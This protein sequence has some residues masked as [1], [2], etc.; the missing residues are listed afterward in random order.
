VFGSSAPAGCCCARSA[1]TALY[2]LQVYNLT[3]YPHLV[4]LLE[5]LGVDTEPSD[6][7]FALS[8]DG[9]AFEWGSRGL[10]ALFCQR[11]NLVSPTFW[12]MVVDVVRFGRGAREVGWATCMVLLYARSAALA[13]HTF[14]TS[15][16]PTAQVLDPAESGRFS[17]MST[18]DYLRLRRYSQAFVRHYFLPMCAAV[19]SVPESQASTWS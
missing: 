5:T 15:P 1:L 18:G 9:G 4:G 12:R 19:W 6:M 16:S 10:A 13:A 8:S 11:R 2:D 17:R 7:S 14:M 3:T